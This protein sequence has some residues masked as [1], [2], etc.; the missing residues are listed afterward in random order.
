MRFLIDRC[1]GRRIADRLRSLG[2]DVI[3]VRERG[4]DPGD[5][6]ILR[7]AFDEHRVLVTMDKD[8]GAL[9]YREGA[10][11]AGV[12]QLPH[13]RS[14]ERVALIERLIGNYTPAQIEG[15]VIVVRGNRVRFSRRS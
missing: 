14:D 3:E 10:A 7:W 5:D 15:A 4:P 11:H 1:A 9:I 13:V 6:V 2:H 12:I 8:F